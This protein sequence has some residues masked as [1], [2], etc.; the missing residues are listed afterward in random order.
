[1]P[2]FG[3]YCAAHSALQVHTFQLLITGAGSTH[4]PPLNAYAEKEERESIYEQ[5]GKKKE[6]E[7]PY[8]TSSTQRERKPPATPQ[9]AVLSSPSPV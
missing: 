2:I 9:T 4:N 7:R 6:E 8:Y 1:M 3:S 5:A